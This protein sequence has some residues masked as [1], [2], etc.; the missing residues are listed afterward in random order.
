MGLDHGLTG[1]PLRRMVSLPVAATNPVA[2]RG[3][4]SAVQTRARVGR[5]PNPTPR[6]RKSTTRFRAGRSTGAGD[7]IAWRNLCRDRP[8]RGK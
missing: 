2:C 6:A 4:N 7:G 1:L 5:A 3:R 8:W